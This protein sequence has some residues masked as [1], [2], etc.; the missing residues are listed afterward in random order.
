MA[1]ERLDRLDV[2]ETSLRKL[3]QLR[4]D[5]AHAYNAL[6]YTFADRGVRLDEAQGLIA[7]A[8]E[9]SPDDAQILDSMGW[10]LFRRGQT[11]AAIEYLQKAWH[12]LPEAEIGAHLGEAL[13]QAG[14]ADEARRVWNQAAASDPENRVLKET[15]ARLRAD[16]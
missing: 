1:A 3:I 14:R 6:G 13:W 10:V 16:R 5:Y 9:I 12:R 4:P 2:M 7:K 15:V 11:E 8:L